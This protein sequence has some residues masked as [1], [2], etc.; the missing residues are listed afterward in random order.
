MDPSET[1]E[2]YATHDLSLKFDGEGRLW[3]FRPVGRPRQPLEAYPTD[4][5]I[6][7][8]LRHA[9][10]KPGDFEL[11]IEDRALPVKGKRAS[12][13]DVDLT[14]WLPWEFRLGDLEAAY[15]NDLLELHLPLC[16]ADS[17][18]PQCL[19]LEELLSA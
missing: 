14:V 12:T 10:I 6:I 15:H 8:V 2:V 5:E 11:D 7:V 17:D 18:L 3:R 19:E 16:R 4:H 1:S 13:K 9:D